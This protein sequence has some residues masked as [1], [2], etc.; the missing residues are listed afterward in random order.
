[1][2]PHYSYHIWFKICRPIRAKYKLSTNCLLVLNGCYC[3]YK[4]IGKPLTRKQLTKFLTYYN[5]KSINIYLSVLIGKGYIK[6]LESK[7]SIRYFIISL[8]GIQ[9]IK[10]LNE[11]YEMQLS[12]FCSQ[13]NITL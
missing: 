8:A 3:H 2:L 6:E 7:G 1:M 11:S 5:P 12:L 4:T 9:V 13:Y 10:E